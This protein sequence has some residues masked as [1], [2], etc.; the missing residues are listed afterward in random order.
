MGGGVALTK[1]F[2]HAMQATAG[3]GCPGRQ[4]ASSRREQLQS[5]SRCGGSAQSLTQ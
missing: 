4:L 2:V 5:L 1:C 3:G